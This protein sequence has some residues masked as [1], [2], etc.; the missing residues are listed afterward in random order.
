MDDLISRKATLETVKKL[1]YETAL[2]S[3]G[4]HQDDE[5]YA[6]IAE[7][8]IGIWIG[9]VPSVPAVPLDKLCEWLS[10]NG[11]CRQIKDGVEFFPV[12][13]WKAMIREMMEKQHEKE[14]E[15]E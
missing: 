4:S 7:N 2:N 8:R 1:L 14:K 5:I 13:Y 9:L 3:Y 15:K 12:Q 6:D 10:K 11:F